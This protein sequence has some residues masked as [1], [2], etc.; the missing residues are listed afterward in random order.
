MRRSRIALAIALTVAAIFTVT[1]VLLVTVDLGRFKGLT[2]KLVSDALGRNFEIRGNF[3]PTIGRSIRLIAEDIH[4]AATGSGQYE[5]L[6][7]VQNL[8]FSIDAWTVVRGPIMIESLSIKGTTINLEKRPD[9]S[10]NWSTG[11]TAILEEDPPA[12]IERLPVVIR[13]LTIRDVTL[14]YDAPSMQRQLV[15]SIDS[16]DE[17][18]STSGEINISTAGNVNETPY[19]LVSKT[20]SIDNLIVL[21]NVSTTFH[22]SL[23][24]IKLSGSGEVDHLNSPRRPALSLQVAGPNAEYLTDILGIQ[25]V[26]T[27]PLRID[28]SVVPA[29]QRMEV[30]TQL[31][32]GEFLLDAKGHFADLQDYE[33]LQVS[34]VGSGPSAAAIGRLFGNETVPEEPFELKLESTIAGSNIEIAPLHLEIGATKIDATANIKDFP[35]PDGAT[36]KV[37]ISG[38]DFGK[39]NKL[40]GLP[41]KLT[42]PFQLDASISALPGRKANVSL[43]ASAKD[44]QVAMKGVV[45]ES[46]GFAGSSIEITASGQSFGTVAQTVDL[47]H[48]PADPFELRLQIDKAATASTLTA[49]NLRIGSD[50][51][52]L[53]GQI[54]DEPFK[55]DTNVKFELSGDDFRKTLTAYGVGADTM[56]AA[57]WSAS[58]NIVRENDRFSIRQATATIGRDRDYT[59]ALDGQ[60]SDSPRLVGSAA[61][62]ALSGKSLDA[63]ASTVG[64]PGFP[65]ERIEFGA[66]LERS[67]GGV[68]ISNGKVLLGNDEV[69]I[70]GTFGDIPLEHGSQLSLKASVKDFKQTLQAFGV[71]SEK[72]PAGPLAF[73]GQI[74]TADNV[75]ILKNTSV[76]LAGGKLTA[77]GQVGGLPTLKS[78]DIT[79]SLA[80]DNLSVLLP[81]VEAFSATVDPYRLNSRIRLRDSEVSVEDLDISLGEAKLNGGVVTKYEPFLKSGTFDINSTAPDFGRLVQR[82]SNDATGAGVPMSFR[83]SGNWAENFWHFDSLLFTLANGRVSVTGSLDGP[84]KFTRTDLQVDLNIADLSNL[85]SLAGRDLPRDQVT[86]RAHLLGTNDKITL[87]DFA[88]KVGDSI[89]DGEFSL[90]DA[91][92]PR[93]DVKLVSKMLD[94]SGYLPPLENGTSKPPASKKEKLL[95]ATPLELTYL[96]KLDA[97]LDLRIDKLILRQRSVNDIV[98][99][100]TLDGGVLA[101]NQFHLSSAHEGEFS[102]ALRLQD[103]DSRAALTLKLSGKQLTLGLP[104]KTPDEVAA[105]PLYDIDTIL[106]GT[107]KTVAELA[108]SLNGFAMVVSGPG[109]IRAGDMQMFTQDFVAQVFNTV[110]PFAKSDPY[111]NIKCATLLLKATDGVISGDPAL[112]VQTDKLNIFASANVDLKTEK[113]SVVLNTVPQTGLGLSLSNLVTPYTKAGG[114]LANPT[115]TLDAQGAIVQGGAAVATAGISFLAVKFKD[116]YLSAKDACGKAI[117]DTRDSFEQIRQQYK[118]TDLAADAK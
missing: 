30:T 26:T 109:K 91:D 77:T 9:G 34:A 60:I 44:L 12:G 63:L 48:A 61:K 102:G 38:P 51:L 50:H 78:A 23:G 41:G 97:S 81:D 53:A 71:D 62:I 75:L 17:S 27:G 83:A 98:L 92:V 86:L 113:L 104:G 101:V 11:T 87:E 114:T 52:T 22:G 32:F 64:F 33:D 39:F 103:S 19:S 73:D 7:S 43:D 100:G 99:A 90:Q 105:L 31:V 49:A 112:V 13:E 10:N 55:R 46:P 72:L 59:L 40:L 47:D 111:S 20:E 56:P 80:G 8:E 6:V 2:E 106:D 84:P 58:G 85:S 5:D 21:G 69:L 79:I 88:A 95:P 117:D 65:A 35:S 54:G 118:A 25:R 28:A 24:E 29:T 115:L 36:A 94:L 15:V 18:I 76:T 108:G 96:H 3:E 74:S 93:A 14:S 67:V 116:R 89:V 68:S 37:D 82:F 4:L 16:V 66:T 107:G 70:D 110:N 45:V 42:G 57:S 1:A